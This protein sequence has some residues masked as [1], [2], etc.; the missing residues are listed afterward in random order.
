MLLSLFE[1][2]QFLEVTRLPGCSNN[3]TQLDLFIFPN[4]LKYTVKCTSFRRLAVD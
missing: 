1:N 2:H 3:D 4:T